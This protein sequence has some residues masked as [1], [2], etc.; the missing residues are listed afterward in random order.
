MCAGRSIGGCLSRESKGG[1]TGQNGGGKGSPTA[2]LRVPRVCLFQAIAPSPLKR[3]TFSPQHP[4]PVIEQGHFLPLLGT[5]AA[6]PVP[7][8]APPKCRK[9]KEGK[10]RVQ[11]VVK[12]KK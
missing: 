2:V 11:R 4:P 3:A 1:E 6:T 7:V 12:K 10:F 8:V 9:K 5:S